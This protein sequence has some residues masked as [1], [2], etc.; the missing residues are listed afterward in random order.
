MNS[1]TMKQL[2]EEERPYEKCL[3]YGPEVLTD[4]ELLAVILRSGTRGISSVALAS[5]ILEA[6][7]GGEQGLLGI[8]RLSMGDLME[9]RG[10]GQVKA[11]QIKCIGELSKRIASV[12][13]KK[14]LDFQNPETIADYYMEQMRHEEQEIMI[15]MM[16]NT[17][18]QLLGETVISRGT[19]NASL[20]SPRDLILAAFRF[21]AVFIIIVHN[22][23]SG[24]PKPSRDDLDITKRIQAACSLVDIPLLDH[25]IIG[26]QRYISFRQEGMLT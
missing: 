24:D 12:S 21:R 15:C 10:I 14:L 13:A 9:F 22:H 11:V 2:P 5:Q 8:H 16:L 19:V 17:K 1:H 23:P 20:V 6:G 26:D 7:A 4:S 3:A 18:N 25:I